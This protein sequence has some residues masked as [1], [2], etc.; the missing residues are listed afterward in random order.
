M[1]F[2]KEEE[3]RERRA[4]TNR[5]ADMNAAFAGGKAAENLLKALE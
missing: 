4:R 1:L 3:A 5:I 2:F